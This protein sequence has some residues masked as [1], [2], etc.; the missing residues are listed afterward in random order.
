MKKILSALALLLVV[1]G[2]SQAP[3][4]EPKNEPTAI[5]TLDSATFV[6][7]MGKTEDAKI[8]IYFGNPKDLTAPLADLKLG[9]LPEG[10]DVDGAAVKEDVVNALKALSLTKAENQNKLSGNPVFFVDLNGVIDA[11]YTRFVVFEDAIMVST[12]EGNVNYNFDEA[13]HTALDEMINKYVAEFA[14]PVEE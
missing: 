14:A 2:C 12:K 11:N 6:E 1:A 4:E 3:K 10:V 13:A 7:E 9:N 8:R 5:T